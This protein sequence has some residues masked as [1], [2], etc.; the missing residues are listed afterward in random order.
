MKFQSIGAEEMRNLFGLAMAYGQVGSGSN[1][2][3]FPHNQDMGWRQQISQACER[4]KEANIPI[5]EVWMVRTSLTFHKN[6]HLHSL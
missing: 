1:V 2:P 5:P 3:S 6:N 4:Y